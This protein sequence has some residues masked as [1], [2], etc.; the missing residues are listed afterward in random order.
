MHAHIKGHSYEIKLQHS[1]SS[2]VFYKVC[3]FIMQLMLM[4]SDGV[5]IIRAHSASAFVSFGGVTVRRSILTS[6][7]GTTHV[8]AYWKLVR[9]SSNH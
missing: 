9:E 4:M 6:G 3:Y 7:A 2:P 5:V 8:I 1:T